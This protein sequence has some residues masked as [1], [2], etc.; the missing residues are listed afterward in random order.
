M[1]EKFPIVSEKLPQ[2]LRGDFLTHTVYVS[3]TVVRVRC[4]NIYHLRLVRVCQQYL[5]RVANTR[6]AETYPRNLF[7]DLNVMS[8]SR[9]DVSGAEIS[10][11]AQLERYV[12]SIDSHS[13]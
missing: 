7:R 11:V 8:Q 13:Q 10:S 3:F 9:P 12:L 1:V 6:D 4:S 2:V 5:R